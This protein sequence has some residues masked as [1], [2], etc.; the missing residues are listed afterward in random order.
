MLTFNS[1]KMPV[2]RDLE[3]LELGQVSFGEGW[4]TSLLPSLR[5]LVYLGLAYCKV[6]DRTLNCLSADQSPDRESICPKLF[7]LSLAGARVTPHAV[8]KLINS[9]LPESQHIAVRKLGETIAP[10]ASSVTGLSALGFDTRD[11]LMPQ[12]HDKVP[13]RWLGLNHLWR[14]DLSL[15][16][17]FEGRVPHVW[18]GFDDKDHDSLR[19][20]GQY[21]WDVEDGSYLGGSRTVVYDGALSAR[22]RAGAD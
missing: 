2:L 13:I 1:D 18:S 22:A 11:I 5:Q 14:G 19:G 7:A 4:L 15:M 8:R 12:Q 16:P 6:T 10:Y 21:R 3:V 17:I 9:R 20:Q